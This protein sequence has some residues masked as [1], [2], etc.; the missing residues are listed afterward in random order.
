M[1]IVKEHY[2]QNEYDKIKEHLNAMKHWDEADMDIY[3]TI[4]N[5]QLESDIQEDVVCVFENMMDKLIN[6][7]KY[8]FFTPQRIVSSSRR[9]VAKDKKNES[10]KI[11]ENIVNRCSQNTLIVLTPSPDVKAVSNASSP[12]A[13]MKSP[14]KLVTSSVTP[15]TSKDRSRTFNLLE[16]P[17]QDTKSQDLQT[18]TTQ[19]SGEIKSLQQEDSSTQEEINPSENSNVEPSSNVSDTES[20]FKFNAKK[21]FNFRKYRQTAVSPAATTEQSDK[22]SA[23][24]IVRLRTSHNRTVPLESDEEEEVGLV[25]K[26][27]GVEK[28]PSN[29]G[30]GADDALLGEDISDGDFPELEFVEEVSPG[31]EKSTPR[32]RSRNKQQHK[33]SMHSKYCPKSKLDFL[34]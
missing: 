1:C 25:Q 7:P 13:K 28:S 30:T 17:V 32:S 29:E 26:K 8:T 20:A 5:D 2:F 31:A 14:K 23:V 9:S 11:N 24:R 19:S 3:P 16:V 10:S 33:K 12:S 18:D 4:I 27:E 22:E 6:E 21:P 15:K 34:Y